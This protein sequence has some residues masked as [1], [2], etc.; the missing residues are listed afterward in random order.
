MG[1]FLFDY[2]AYCVNLLI[3]GHLVAKEEVGRLG[4]GT[5]A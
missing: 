4:W 2:G 3:M 5:L 1:T